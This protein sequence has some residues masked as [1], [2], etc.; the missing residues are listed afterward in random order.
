MAQAQPGQPLAFLVKRAG[1]S[2]EE[3]SPIVDRIFVG[4]ECPGIEDY[5][6]VLLQDPVVS[7][8]HFEIRL[9]IERDEAFL[10]DTS[11]NG[12]YIN[13]ARA[14]RAVPAPLKAGDWIKAGS[15][16]FA[17]QSAHFAGQAGFNPRATMAQINVSPVVLVVGD[18]TNYSTISQLIGSDVVAANL[19]SL[20]E[21]LTTLLAQHRGTLNHYAGDAL[22]AVWEVDYIRDANERAVEFA[23][24]ASRRVTEV[25][26]GLS[27]RGPDGLPVQMGWAV[28]S[29]L[30]AITTMTHA[31]VSV[32]GDTTNLVF[33][34]SGYAAR[35]GRA[36]VLVLDHV[37]D[38]VEDKFVWGE[39][40]RVMTKGRS[41]EETVY[42]AL[43]KKQS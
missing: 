15:A 31:A 11:T 19:Q 1:E 23:L 7:R 42:P 32:V 39:P 26:P 40:E 2:G 27:L 22:Y 9:D 24:A 3:S 30:A 35:E 6:R 43:A 12:T 5:R 25:A 33:R 20:Y 8:T 37:H 18:I 34:L 36:P 21:E 10:V 16:E 14:P 17:F 13:G 4:R 41:G 29:G 28:A 38:A